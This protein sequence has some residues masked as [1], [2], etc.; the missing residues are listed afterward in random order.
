MTAAPRQAAVVALRISKLTAE[1]QIY[2]NR[3]PG[4][5]V[6]GTI[7]AQHDRKDRQD[8]V[9]NELSARNPMAF[10]L[11]GVGFV[12]LCAMFNH[13]PVPSMEPRFA[14]V[15]REMAQ[16]GQFLMPIKN[17]IP[18]VE[19]PP[20]YAWLG[21]AGE[22][23]GLPTPAAVR[24][25]GYA[26]LLLWIW[27]LGRL[28]R[29]LFPAWPSTMLP[30]VGAA[31]PAIL[32][33]FFTA[34]SDSLLI[35]GVLVAFTGFARLRQD[36]EFRR[37]PWEMWLG[38]TLATA[39]KGPVGLAVTLPIMGIEIIVAGATR[40][41]SE[42]AALRTF[43]RSLRE[44]RRLS[45]LRGLGLVLALN[46]PWYVLTGVKEG[47]EFVQAVVI[48]QNFTRFLTGFDH[49]RPWWYYG[50]TLIYDLFPLSL[51]FPVG[52]YFAARRPNRF[53][54]RLIL[55][56][57]LFTL[58]FFSLS[59]SKQG[60]YIL[61]AAPAIAALGL[62]GVQ[63][64]WSASGSRR[65]FQY[66]QR[67]AVGVLVVFGLAVIF[68]LPFY[69]HE[70]GGV[71]GFRKIRDVR[72]N[73]P[74]RIVAFRWPRSMTLYEL[75]APMDFV[76]SSRELYHRIG[77]GDIRA[78]DYLLADKRYLPRPSKTPK[79]PLTPAPAPPYFELV[80][81]VKAEKD[82]NLYRVLPGAADLPVPDTPTPPPVHW[83]DK[84]FDTD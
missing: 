48:Y 83:R 17:G 51:L 63:T 30:L 35:L 32:Y 7:K 56:W 6:N 82:M 67:W 71:E 39:A 29:Q 42:G 26:A 70:I 74:G 72:A 21:L 44:L 57:S 23:A 50:K 81:S 33:H 12:Y 78:G 62:V 1:G 2:V 8:G 68:A 75:G 36:Q 4:A 59:Q 52:V 11:G 40:N 55:I 54:L 47:W 45:W 69:A 25:P 9:R 28:Q 37:F 38:V 84:R 41:S 31:L 14:E 60:K 5:C 76:R 53:P 18:Y 46:L 24:L 27:W 10:L 80:L 49:L 77:K 13:G 3:C 16:T 19:Y 65:L 34:Q 15:V 20:L 66:L 79:Y 61:P 58:L 43:G 73:A 22:L 64:L